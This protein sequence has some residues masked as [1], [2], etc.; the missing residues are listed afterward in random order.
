[1]SSIR[2]NCFLNVKVLLSFPG[3]VD[4]MSQKYNQKAQK[5][6]RQLN[7]SPTTFM[8]YVTL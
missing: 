5:L 1:M 4:S 3:K 2:L 8:F 7:R 6:T